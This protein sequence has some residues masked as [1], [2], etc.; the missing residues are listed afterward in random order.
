MF[1]VGL[2]EFLNFIYSNLSFPSQLLDFMLYLK[3]C[4]TEITANKEE[5]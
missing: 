1:V 5:I 2:E 3:A 4:L